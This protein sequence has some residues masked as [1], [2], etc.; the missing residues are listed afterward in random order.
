MEEAKKIGDIFTASGGIEPERNN[1]LV[2]SLGHWASSVLSLQ[3]RQCLRWS[4]LLQR[5]CALAAAP[6]SAIVNMLNKREESGEGGTWRGG[7]SGPTRSMAVRKQ[8]PHWKKYFF[9]MLYSRWG[10]R[11]CQHSYIFLRCFNVVTK[12][13]KFTTN[14]GSWQVSFIISGLASISWVVGCPV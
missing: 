3:I 2:V 6:L 7:Q 14:P 1:G 11:V 12:R 10:P 9:L 13:D 4:D 8:V 5:L